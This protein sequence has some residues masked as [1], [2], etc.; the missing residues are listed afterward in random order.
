MKLRKKF[1]V[2]VIAIAATWLITSTVWAGSQ[3]HR[4]LHDVTIGFTGLVVGS[5][6]LNH[7]FFA[8][9]PHYGYEHRHWRGFPIYRYGYGNRY[10]DGAYR[11]ERHGHFGRDEPRHDSHTDR[12]RHGSN[13]H[14]RK[15]QSRFHDRYESHPRGDRDRDH[16]DGR[17]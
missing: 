1:I 17:R 7:P 11:H 12:F 16:H 13:E 14:W 10:H 6:P 9:H 4:S 2:A 3:P 15:D 5:M 8:H